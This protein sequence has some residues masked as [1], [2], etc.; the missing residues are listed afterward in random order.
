MTGAGYTPPVLIE[1]YN[2]FKLRHFCSR[3]NGFLLA[4][5]SLFHFLFILGYYYL[6]WITSPD[7]LSKKAFLLDS[8][9]FKSEQIR[10]FLYSTNL[11]EQKYIKNTNAKILTLFFI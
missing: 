9:S 3:R 1:M 6:N 4:T 5:H 2:F 11:I 7:A 8:C 10:R